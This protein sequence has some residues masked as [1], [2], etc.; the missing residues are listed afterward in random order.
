[1]V[2]QVKA[3]RTSD[4]QMFDNEGDAAQ[5]EAKLKV[6]QWA[7]EARVCR[8]GEWDADMVVSA[9]IDDAHALADILNAYVRARPL[10][11]VFD[12]RDVHKVEVKS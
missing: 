2:A 9:I 11:R 7:D 3:W 10:G 8:G 6:G 1:M 4:G 5:H 12:D